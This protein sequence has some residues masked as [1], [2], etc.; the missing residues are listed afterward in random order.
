MYLRHENGKAIHNSSHYYLNL[1]GNGTRK[2]EFIGQ[3]ANDA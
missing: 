2:K 1:N 3:I